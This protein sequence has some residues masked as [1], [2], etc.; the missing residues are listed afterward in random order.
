MQTRDDLT[1]AGHIAWIF[2]GC[3]LAI[4]VYAAAHFQNLHDHVSALFA[5]I[6]APTEFITHSTQTMPAQQRPLHLASGSSMFKCTQ[7]DGS[8]TYQDEECPKGINSSKKTVTTLEA[9]ASLT[10]VANANHQYTTTLTIN[11]T[12]VIGHVDTGAT[13]VALSTDTARRMQI[14]SDGAVLKQMQTANG[15]IMSV[16]KIIPVLKVGN[17]ELYNVEVSIAPNMPTLIGMSALSHLNFA[18]E[19]GNLVLSKR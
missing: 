17:F 14:T 1:N 19:N 2:L 8:T 12:T 4:M 9:P 16:N 13:F 11:G 15:A 5:N 6:S 3:G 7:A 18:H 10:L